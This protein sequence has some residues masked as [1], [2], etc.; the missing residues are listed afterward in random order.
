[1]TVSQSITQSERQTNVQRFLK[2]VYGGETFCTSL[3]PPRPSQ[4]FFG[5]FFACVACF[6]TF[7]L[8]CY[9][10]YV[11]FFILL[12]LSVLRRYHDDRPRLQGCIPVS[13]RTET[14]ATPRP[15]KG[16]TTVNRSPSGDPT[17]VA[18]ADCAS[19]RALREPHRPIG[20]AAA[21]G[22]HLILFSSVV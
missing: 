1:M 21:G 4:T 15:G 18:V 22:P 6:R 10:L 13:R 20:V 17:R 7:I 3:L 19:A 5:D 9:V 11:S 2:V 14:V 16:V 12:H 8:H